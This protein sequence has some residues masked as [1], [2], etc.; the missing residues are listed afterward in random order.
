M[1]SCYTLFGYM[2]DEAI[3]QLHEKFYHIVELARE[4]EK[5]PRSFGTDELLTSA[6]IHLIELIGDYGESMG[7]TDL[8]KMLGVTKGAV[9]Q[10]LKRLENK[11]LC[12]KQTDPA[13]GSRIIVKL[14]NKGKTAFFAHRHWHETMD[15]GFK[16]FFNNLDQ[17][18]AAFLLETLTQVE[19]FLERIMG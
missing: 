12:L 3:H 11:A 6:E 2:K 1:F 14:T 4:V 9:S 15:G 16:K 7:V 8:A 5:T 13:N 18:K 10:N 17:E 19:D